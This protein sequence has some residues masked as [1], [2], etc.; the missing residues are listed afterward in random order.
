MSVQKL[1]TIMSFLNL[2]IVILSYQNLLI[3]MQ[4]MENYRQDLDSP[5]IQQQY[6]QQNLNLDDGYGF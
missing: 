4:H 5:E 1:P 2:V 6:Y 3:R